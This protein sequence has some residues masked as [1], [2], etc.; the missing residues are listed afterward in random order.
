MDEISILRLFDEERQRIPDDDVTFSSTRY[1][2]RAIR[3]DG[4]WAGIV[5]SSF[6]AEE[7]ETVITGE[8]EFFAKLNQ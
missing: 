2:V 7:T 1:V 5:Y 4:S 6:P 3:S 8:I